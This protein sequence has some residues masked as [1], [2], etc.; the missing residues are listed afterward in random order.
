MNVDKLRT[1]GHLMPQEK[2]LETGF[3]E[4]WYEAMTI[5]D[6]GDNP[7]KAMSHGD[8]AITVKAMGWDGEADFENETG[9]NFSD[10]EGCNFLVMGSRDERTS[11]YTM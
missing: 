8:F 5:D 1:I 10:V 2:M 7:W 3:C 9:C 6:G 11:V 4:D